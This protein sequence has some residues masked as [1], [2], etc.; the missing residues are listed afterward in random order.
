MDHHLRYTDGNRLCDLF[1]HMTERPG[2][3]TAQKQVQYSEECTNK[4]PLRPEGGQSYFVQSEGLNKVVGSRLASLMSAQP[5][6][7][8]TGVCRVSCTFA[9]RLAPISSCLPKTAFPLVS[10]R[11]VDCFMPHPRLVLSQ[12]RSEISRPTSTP[13]NG[14]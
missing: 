5:V 8:Y 10:S 9:A 12:E 2:T 11:L 3:D 6:I 1:C 4:R 7:R 14:L 13:W